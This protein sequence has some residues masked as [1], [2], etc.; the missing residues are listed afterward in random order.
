MAVI[1]GIYGILIICLSCGGYLAHV[2]TSICGLDSG[3]TRISSI[4]LLFVV[5]S[6]IESYSYMIGLETMV[7]VMHSTLL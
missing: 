4:C 3:Y 2:E 1:P 7:L 6:G 5:L